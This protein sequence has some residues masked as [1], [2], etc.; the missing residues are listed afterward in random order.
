MII[1]TKPTH[2]NAELLKIFEAP[3]GKGN[4]VQELPL[5]TTVT[6]VKIENGWV[7]IA[8]DG[9]ALGYVAGATLHKLN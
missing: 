6:L 7:L 9:K 3:G 4:V 1:S 8:K 5:F 2:V